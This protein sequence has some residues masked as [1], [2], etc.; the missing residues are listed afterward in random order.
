M[1]STPSLEFFTIVAQNYLAFALVLGESVLSHHPDATF[2]VFLVDDPDHRWQPSLEARGFRTI[3]PEQIPLPDYRKFVF[4]YDVLEASTGV[5]PLVIQSILDRGVEKVIYLDPDILCFRRFDE[6]LAA[7]DQYCIVLT[8]HI[9]SPI[10]EGLFPDEREFM[11]SGIFNLGFVA[12]R[13]CEET[14]RFVGWWARR[15]AR[16]CLNEPE[17]GLFVDQ[18]WMDVVP[19]CFDRVLTMRNHAY[20]VA[21]WNLHERALEERQGVLY[22]ARS[23]ERVAFV[24]FSGF[25]V[26]D[27]NAICK[28]V[29]RNPLGQAV[30]KKRIS[31]MERQD[32][33]PL[34][35]KYRE[36]V[37]SAKMADFTRIPYAYATYANGEPISKLERALY[38]TSP[39]WREAEIDP[40]ATGPGSFWEAC[41]RAG[42]RASGGWKVGPADEVVEKYGRYMRMI[43]FLL[44][45]CL[46]VLGTD[47]YL[48]FS[49]Y[50][51]HQLLPANHGFLLKRR[52]HHSSGAKESAAP[53]ASKAEGNKSMVGSGAQVT[54]SF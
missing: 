15:L 48:A 28:Y 8:P 17:A 29:R 25:N 51:R 14:Q 41:R 5:K 13:N 42:V 49:K 1:A 47:L 21:F 6:V 46:R 23:G 18:K 30:A 4:Q 26:G 54:D 52:N 31:L 40:F 43:E 20:N 10:P 16:E 9:C 34:F 35:Q 38:R 2:S 44:R 39:T 45:L 50:M 53:Y 7:L 3:Y 24:H 33:I 19:A 12:L 32:L 27:A 37:F 36:M 22:D 11:A